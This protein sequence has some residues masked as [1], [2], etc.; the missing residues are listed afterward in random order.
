M[1][2]LFSSQLLVGIFYFLF[3]DGK[4]LHA[5]IPSEAI[6]D[7]ALYGAAGSVEFYPVI[8]QM[9]ANMYLKVSQPTALNRCSHFL[10]T[11]PIFPRFSSPS[12][13]SYALSC[14]SPGLSSSS[15]ASTEWPTS[16][17]FLLKKTPA[18]N[19]SA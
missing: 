4:T 14:S 17:Y 5:A 16:K 7:F 10:E 3:D 18:V 8:C 9:S 11:S 13:A 1:N 19:S 15:P 6:C 12:Y 2:A